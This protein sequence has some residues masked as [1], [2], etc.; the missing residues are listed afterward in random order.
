MYGPVYVWPKNSAFFV[1]QKL[2]L[3][4][5][6]DSNVL[7][8]KIYA[9]VPSASV[10]AEVTVSVLWDRLGCTLLFSTSRLNPDTSVNLTLG[11]HGFAGANA[12]RK[13]KAML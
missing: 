1:I 7:L 10:A 8:L 5:R 4:I 12:Q 9:A 11:S 3:S 2:F 13:C 6:C